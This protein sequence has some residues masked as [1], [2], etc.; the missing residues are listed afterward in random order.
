MSHADDGWCV[1]ADLYSDCTM[2]TRLMNMEKEWPGAV[3][4]LLKLGKLTPVIHHH[5]RI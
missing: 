5:E 3:L 2:S 1:F 4:L